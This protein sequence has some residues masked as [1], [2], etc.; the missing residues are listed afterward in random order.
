[1]AYAVQCPTAAIILGLFLT[2]A[3]GAEPITRDHLA[4]VDGD[5]VKVDGREWRLKGYDTA[6]TAKAWCEGERRLGIIAT[7]RLEALIANARALELTGGETTDRYNR[8]LGTL[9]VDGVDTGQTMIAE[10]LAR[11]YNGGR[12]KGWC[13][14]DSRDDLVPGEQKP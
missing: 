6:E 11:P 12:R 9:L 4:V 1:M 10:G 13:S 3:A 2:P 5:S 7:K 8:P 14:R